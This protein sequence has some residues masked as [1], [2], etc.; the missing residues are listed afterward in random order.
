MA[1][2]ACVWSD[3]SAII[4]KSRIRI[5]YRWSLFSL[6]GV[7]FVAACTQNRYVPAE[8]PHAPDSP[9]AAASDNLHAAVPPQG[10]FGGTNDTGRPQ[11]EL[12]GADAAA[13]KD[14]LRREY[15]RWLGTRHRL[16]GN[17]GNGIDCSAFVQAVYRKVFRIDL[18]RTTR[19]QV[20]QGKPVAYHD[21]RVGDLVFFKPP[22]YPRHVGIYLGDSQFVHASKTSGVTVSPI[23]RYY[24]QPH[25]W[26]ARRLLAD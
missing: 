4:A 18:P 25:F 13:T 21:M 9:P 3:M 6:I 1:F 16:G 12:D 24:W 22:D 2:V 7:L 26:T 17:D 11:E 10:K 5:I 19:G 8:S 23:D 14:M 20:R 15:S